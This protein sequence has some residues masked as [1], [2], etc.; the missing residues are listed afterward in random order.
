VAAGDFEEWVR[1]W[2]G[3]NAFYGRL[4][5]TALP[6]EV[7]RSTWQRFFDAD[8]P[9]HFLVA[10]RG[11]GGLVGLAHYALHH[12]TIQVG[13][14]CYLRDL[15]TEPASRGQGVG[16]ALLEAVF[17]RAGSAGCGRVYW[18]TH[19]T[20]AAGIRLYDKVADRSGFIVYRKTL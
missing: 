13:P 2:D 16:R 8:E 10:E 1:L 17:E 4:G 14:T 6:T 20:T 11:G 9:V 19:E 15:C 5:A 3:Y 18:Q 7:T 12:S